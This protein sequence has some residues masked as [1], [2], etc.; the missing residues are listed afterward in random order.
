MKRID[1]Y[2]ETVGK[3]AND[4]LESVLRKVALPTK[5]VV[6]QKKTI[7]TPYRMGTLGKTGIRNFCLEAWL[8]MW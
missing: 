4:E 3:A 8:R 5:I 6:L 7:S 2:V 1:S